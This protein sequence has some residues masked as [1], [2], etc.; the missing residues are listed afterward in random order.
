[1]CVTTDI[2]STDLDM[3]M[4]VNGKMHQQAN[5]ESMLFAPD[6]IVSYIP[7]RC[8]LELDDVL[9]FES[10]ANPGVVELGDEIEIRYDGVGTLRNW[11][12]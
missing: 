7:G 4:T 9:S 11:V 2:D 1:M 12:E 5:T 10:P 3:E 6:K 8:T